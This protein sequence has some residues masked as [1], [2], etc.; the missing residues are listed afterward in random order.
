MS[1]FYIILLIR[2]YGAELAA[3]VAPRLQQLV[4]QHRGRIHPPAET[5]LSERDAILITY[6]DQV[7]QPGQMPL[8]SLADFCETHLR[9]AVSGIHILP[10]YPS[11]SDDGFSD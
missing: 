1:S 8:Q 11:S 4:E 7:R 6:P 9:G 2:I 3:Q 5:T 10:F